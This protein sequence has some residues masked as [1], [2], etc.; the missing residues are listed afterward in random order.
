MKEWQKKLE[1]VNWMLKNRGFEI[2]NIH[3][4]RSRGFYDGQASKGLQWILDNFERTVEFLEKHPNGIRI[5]HCCCF[6]TKQLTEEETT[7]RN[8]LNEMGLGEKK[9]EHKTRAADVNIEGKETAEYINF[10]GKIY[11]GTKRAFEVR[12]NNDDVTKIRKGIFKKY[13]EETS[14][15][16]YDWEEW[17]TSSD[18]DYKYADLYN[19]GWLWRNEDVKRLNKSIE[20]KIKKY[21]HEAC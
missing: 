12:V 4:A 13:N 14:E 21:L 10:I 6:T 17:Q 1:I 18:Y 15:M 16:E 8:M 5:T 9:P 3:G 19:G 20:R 11:D 7:S 2:V